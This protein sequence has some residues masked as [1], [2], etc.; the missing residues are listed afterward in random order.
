MLLK[1]FH[2]AS[3]HLYSVKIIRLTTL[4]CLHWDA[5]FK[6]FA[7]Q[8]FCQIRLTGEIKK[9]ILHLNL[10]KRAHS[11]SSLSSKIDDSKFLMM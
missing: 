6:T 1:M 4:L 10:Y 9:K 7:S 5:F 11:T 3:T 8:L 2:S